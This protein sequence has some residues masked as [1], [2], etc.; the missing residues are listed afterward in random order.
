MLCDCAGGCGN[1]AVGSRGLVAGESEE[2]EDKAMPF[3][4]INELL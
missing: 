4:K 1:K 3:E 2:K